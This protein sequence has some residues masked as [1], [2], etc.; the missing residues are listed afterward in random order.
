MNTREKILKGKRDIILSLEILSHYN[1]SLKFFCLR[2][3]RSEGFFWLSFLSLCHLF[4]Q[5]YFSH[6]FLSLPD[7]PMLRMRSIL[8]ISFLLCQLSLLGP[9]FSYLLWSSFSAI[10]LHLPILLLHKQFPTHGSGFLVPEP[11]QR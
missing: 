5:P 4:I 3:A 1:L 9:R 6:C 8:I 2:G 7:I 11:F 10:L